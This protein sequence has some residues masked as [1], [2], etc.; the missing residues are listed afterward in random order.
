MSRTSYKS[1]E[2]QIPTLTQEL[3]KTQFITLL[4]WYASSYTSEMS[5]KYFAEYL[6]A[7]DIPYT[8]DLVSNYITYHPNIG[9]VCRIQARGGKL[10]ASSCRWI[11][12]RVEEFKSF[13]KPVDQYNITAETSKPIEKNEKPVVNIQDRMKQQVSRCLGELE[14]CMDEAILS[15]FKTTPSPLRVMKEHGIKG[16]QA[17][18]IILWFKRIRD[19][20]RVAHSG[21]DSYL[22]EAYSNF[23]KSELNKLANYCDQIMTDGLTMVKESLENRSPRKKKKRL[24]EQVAKR[25]RYKLQDEALGLTSL[26][27]MKIVESLHAWTYNTKTRMLTLHTAD[28]ASGLTFKGTSVMNTSKT[29]CV[30]KRLRKPKE[31]IHEVMTGGKSI[32]KKLMDSLTTKAAPYRNRLTADVVILRVHA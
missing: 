15:N 3:S 12:T 29:L 28:D 5:M 23:S 8:S 20:F 26:E 21:D 19:E 11:R 17:Q 31:T 1:V 4:N 18:Q 27:P 32:V 7:N 25:V 10:D 9:Y 14:G 22:R 30:S 2:P 6:K 13:K 24:P 16:P